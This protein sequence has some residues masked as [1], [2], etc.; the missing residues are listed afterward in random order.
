S[1]DDKYKSVK[2]S[3]LVASAGRCTR[4]MN[5]RGLCLRQRTKIAQKLPRDL[6]GKKVES[7]QRLI[8]KYRKEYAFELSQIGNMDKTPMT[9]NLLSNRTVTGVGEKPVLIKTIG[10]EKKSILRWF[11]RVWQTDQSS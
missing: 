3:M 7:F 6:E 8:I 1:K 11:Y 2:P 9:F 10:H 4:F 5:R